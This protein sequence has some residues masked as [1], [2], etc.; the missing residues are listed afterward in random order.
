M[1][2][3]TILYRLTGVLLLV[4]GWQRLKS[5]FVSNS[6]LLP[7][8]AEPFLFCVEVLLG[9]CLLMRWAPGATWLS[10]LAVYGA[11]AAASLITGVQG[12]GSCGCFGRLP[13][14]PW[15]TFSVDVGAIFVILFNRPSWTP[16]EGVGWKRCLPHAK[17][18]LCGV[19]LCIALGAVL[20]VVRLGSIKPL[21]SWLAEVV[22][23]ETLLVEPRVVM[24][25]AVGR[26]ESRMVSVRITNKGQ[27]AV[28][29]IGGSPEW[30]SEGPES[31]LF[32][33]SLASGD[34]CELTLTLRFGGVPGAV[35][36]RVWI[37]TDNPN[38]QFLTTVVMG[39]VR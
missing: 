27:E 38:D 11:F 31:N 21:D 17:Q 34:C 35:R 37:M 29:L 33:R 6:P 15:L 25:G 32:P 12:H 5:G 20:L 7:A 36:K 23:S 16:A 19:A 10:G 8:T 1:T 39:E 9:S 18:I 3:L 28:R 14:N 4:A 22:R 26:G 2:L 30:A 24:V 13:V